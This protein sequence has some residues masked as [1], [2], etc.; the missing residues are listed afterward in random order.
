MASA[1]RLVPRHHEQHEVVVVVAV[2][3]RDP[4]AGGL[5]HELADEVRGGSTQALERRRRP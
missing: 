3:E 5:V 2:A 4:V 1:R